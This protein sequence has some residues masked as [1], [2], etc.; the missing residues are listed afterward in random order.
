MPTESAPR[1]S[2]AAISITGQPAGR[3]AWALATFFGAGRLKPGPGTWGSL[4]AVGLWAGF[5]KLTPPQWHAPAAAIGAIAA[6]AAGIP[7]CTRVARE[8][9]VHDPSFV[10]ID[11]VCGQFIA[12]IGAPLNWKSVVAGF[13]LFRAFDIVKPFPARRL[14]RLHGG[15][16]IMLDDVAAGA[17]ALLVMFLLRRYGILV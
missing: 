5:A 13:I 14:E 1:E 8:S 3:W 15:A 10:V 11:E 9:G 12:L 7:A 16:G 2:A 6:L 4:A 17:Y